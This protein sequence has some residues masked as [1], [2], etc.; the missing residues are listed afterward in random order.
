MKIIWLCSMIIPQIAQKLKLS[1]CPMCGWLNDIA[2]TLDRSSD[3]ELV[4]IAPQSVSV[5]NIETDWGEKSRFVGVYIPDITTVTYSDGLEN[6]FHEILEKTP[7]DIVHIFGTEYMHTLAMVQAFNKPERTVIH[8]QGL[9]SVIARHYYADLPLRVIYGTLLS[10]FY[11]RQEIPR[12]KNAFELRGKMERSAIEKVN[13][14][15]GRTHWDKTCALQINPQ[16]SYYHVEELLRDTFF[17][18]AWQIERCVSDCIFMTQGGYPIKGLHIALEA[19]AIVKEKYPTI[20]LC[21]AGAKTYKVKKRFGNRQY[22]YDLYIS[23]LIQKYGLE[24]N[25]TFIGS[26]SADEIKQQMLQ[27][28]IYLLPSSIENSSNSLG[29]AALLG[30]P[31]VASFVGGTPSIIQHEYSGL[32]YPADE[33]YML[34]EEIIRLLTDEG[35]CKRLGENAR[36]MA[37]TRYDRENAIRELMNTYKEIWGEAIK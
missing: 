18:G 11:Q 24:G 13:H 10:H 33:S 15:M 8:I 1:S 26:C 36:R 17:K 35:L 19:L 21:V 28:R 34:A 20:N 27:S 25:V 23:E 12:E 30:M 32:L 37:Q 16:V 31:I 29:E 4:V 14:V 3:I 2:D 7:P 6:N 5:E 9:V 22:S